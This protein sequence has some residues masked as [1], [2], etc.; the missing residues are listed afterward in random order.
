VYGYE[1]EHE[2]WLTLLHAPEFQASVDDIVVEFGTA[3]YQE[4]MD[5]FT[6][7]EEVPYDELKDVWQQTTQPNHVAASD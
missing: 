5:R 2:F 6:R 7:G 3:R 1:E 4:V